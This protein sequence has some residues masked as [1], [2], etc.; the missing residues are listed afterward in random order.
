[1]TTSVFSLCTRWSGVKMPISLYRYL[2]IKLC[3]EWSL[4]LL[5]R[6]LK[7]L[8]LQ[9]KAN[10]QREGVGELLQAWNCT[11][12]WHHPM[13]RFLSWCTTIYISCEIQGPVLSLH[14]IKCLSSAPIP[15]KKTPYR[16]RFNIFILCKKRQI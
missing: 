12:E 9:S 6:L 3:S 11:E 4:K 10:L 16:K 5:C 13:T 15:L 2:S 1:M 7:Y 14:C 8:Q